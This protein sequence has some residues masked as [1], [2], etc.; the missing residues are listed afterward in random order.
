MHCVLGLYPLRG[1]WRMLPT[2][3]QVTK[4][5]YS[6][7]HTHVYG[8]SLVAQLVKNPPAMQ[9]AW[10]WSLGWEDLLEKGKA[11]PTSVFW[12]GESHGLY[13][14]WGHK[15]S[16][17]TEGLAPSPSFVCLFRYS[18]SHLHLCLRLESGTSLPPLP[19]LQASFSVATFNHML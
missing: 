10:V 8:A 6:G 16:G 9:E 19:T 18:F 2:F 12:P 5:M 7:P 11:I 1:P 15:E 14:L 3:R 13:S 4:Y 17:T